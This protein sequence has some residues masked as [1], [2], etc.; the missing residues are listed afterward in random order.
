MLYPEKTQNFQ[1]IFIT[2]CDINQIVILP[3]RNSLIDIIIAQKYSSVITFH[4]WG[5]L[6]YYFNQLI[7]KEISLEQFM[8]L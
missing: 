7:K 3:E 4:K 6:R 2:Y 8:T 5:F 1:N